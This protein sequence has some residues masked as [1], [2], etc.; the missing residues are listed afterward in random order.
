LCV[1]PF[2]ML[3]WLCTVECSSLFLLDEDSGMLISSNVPVD[4]IVYITSSITMLSPLPSSLNA[5]T[6]SQARRLICR[7]NQLL[8]SEDTDKTSKG[9]SDSITQLI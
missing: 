8:L 9:P 4:E 3:R 5:L 7:I 2:Y 1:P 6:G